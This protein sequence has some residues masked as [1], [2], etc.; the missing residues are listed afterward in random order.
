MGK[1][2]RTKGAAGEREF[3]NLLKDE[4]GD[5]PE[6]KRNLDQYQE[7]ACDL[8]IANYAIEI[9]RQEALSIGSWWKQACDNADG[10]IPALAYRQSPFDDGDG[11]A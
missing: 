7:S 11:A 1:S 5:L 9:K 8:V 3:I 4:L 2:Q 6:L 10:L